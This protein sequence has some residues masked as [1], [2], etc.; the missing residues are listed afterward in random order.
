MNIKKILVYEMPS[1]AAEIVLRLRSFQ[2]QT[3]V[4]F[5][6]VVATSLTEAQ[7]RLAEVDVAIIC[8]LFEGIQLAKIAG[9]CGIPTLLTR[10]ER[11]TRLPTAVGELQFFNAEDRHAGQNL[12]LA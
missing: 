4:Q 12:V 10:Q 7:M 1:A 9:N 3:G 5:E 11:P 6:I 8:G 2:K